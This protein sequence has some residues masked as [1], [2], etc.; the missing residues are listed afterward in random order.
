MGNLPNEISPRGFFP[1]KK[2]QQNQLLGTE[3]HLAP[4]IQLQP[5]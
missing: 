1:L 3:K 4:K 5:E 2:H